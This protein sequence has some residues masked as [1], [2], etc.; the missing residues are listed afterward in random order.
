MSSQ[1]RSTG[2]QEGAGWVREVTAAQESGGIGR[3]VRAAA[4]VH[5]VRRVGG[6]RLWRPKDGVG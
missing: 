1:S 5:V 6:A 2:V 4:V 3:A